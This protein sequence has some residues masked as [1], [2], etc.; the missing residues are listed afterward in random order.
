MCVLAFCGFVNVL[1]VN[2]FVYIWC[3]YV[4]CAFC[5]VSGC[6]GGCYMCVVCLGCIG[7]EYGSVCDGRWCVCVFVCMR[8]GRCV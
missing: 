7:L 8:A 4:V 3:V 5:D 2:A 1:N 6:F